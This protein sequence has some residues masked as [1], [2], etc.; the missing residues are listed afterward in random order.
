MILLF[1]TAIVAILPRSWVEKPLVL[2]IM[3]MIIVA[4]GYGVLQEIL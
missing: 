4:V 1:Y 3:I 2:M